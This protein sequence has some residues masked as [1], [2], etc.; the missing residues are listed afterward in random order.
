MFSFGTFRICSTIE[1]YA[2][3]TGA[4]HDYEEVNS[5]ELWAELLTKDIKKVR[6]QEETLEDRE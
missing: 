4:P 6:D 2:R 5:P 3:L 1:E